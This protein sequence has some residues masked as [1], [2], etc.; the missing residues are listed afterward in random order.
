MCNLKVP[1]LFFKLLINIWINVD[2]SRVSPLP[3][4]QSTGCFVWIK[5]P[6]TQPNTTDLDQASS[7]LCTSQPSTSGPGLVQPGTL[8]LHP[9]LEFTPP[10]IGQLLSINPQSTLRGV[11]CVANFQPLTFNTLLIE[12][13][14]RKNGKS[15]SRLYLTEK[16]YSLG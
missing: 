8:S 15:N 12:S 3:I 5:S 6:H 1:E 10:R 16:Q 14:K 9:S 4:I 13:Q 7:L 2:K 11:S